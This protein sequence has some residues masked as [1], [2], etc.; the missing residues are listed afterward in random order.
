MI[1][2]SVKVDDSIL[3]SRLAKQ[4]LAL[5]NLPQEGLKEF[6]S[7]TPR[8]TGNARNNTELTA[9][10]EIRGDYPYA[11]RLDQGWSRQAPKGMIEPF[12]L[13]WEKQIKKIARIK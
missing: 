10:N 3:K 1:K 5:K 13:W 7:L 8:R 12:T 2:I 11:Q 6:K 9:R 4:Q